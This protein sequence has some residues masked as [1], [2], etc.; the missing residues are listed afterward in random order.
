MQVVTQPLRVAVA[1][2]LAIVATPALGDAIF[3]VDDTVDAIDANP[4]DGRCATASGACTLRAAVMEAN[5]G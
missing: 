4:G 5:A 2:A 3:I 1:A